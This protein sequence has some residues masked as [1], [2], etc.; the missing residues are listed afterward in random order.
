MNCHL[1]H[2]HVHTI[3]IKFA[4][5]R[6]CNTTE[7]SKSIVNER[8]SSIWS[9]CTRLNLCLFKIGGYLCGFPIHDTTGWYKSSSLSLARPL[10]LSTVLVYRSLTLS[11]TYWT[12]HLWWQLGKSPICLQCMASSGTL[13][14]IARS[15][16]W[17]HLCGFLSI[18]LAPGAPRSWWTLDQQSG[19]LN[20]IYLGPLHVCNNCVAWSLRKASNRESGTFPWSLAGVW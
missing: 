13:P 10:E 11:I 8:H 5:G 3:L 19:S 1:F 16:N 12:E 9:H 17:A 15:L 2:E 4:V 6:K 14:N 20:G 18:S 7:W